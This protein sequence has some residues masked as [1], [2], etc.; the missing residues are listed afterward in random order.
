LK[1]WLSTWWIGGGAPVSGRISV[2]KEWAGDAVQILLQKGAIEGADEA[3]VIDALQ[4][5]RRADAVI[6]KAGVLKGAVR[7]GKAV[8]DVT[9]E[10][11][12]DI[13]VEAKAVAAARGLRKQRAAQ[14][15]ASNRAAFLS[16]I[17]A[18]HTWSASRWRS[19]IP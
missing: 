1:S 17:R 12:G 9:G 18:L 4:G 8:V 7:G 3:V 10:L 6:A 16:G 13:L 14:F 11:G 19:R 15:R 2:S 5:A